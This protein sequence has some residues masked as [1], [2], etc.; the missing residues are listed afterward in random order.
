V[1][2][3]SLSSRYPKTTWLRGTAVPSPSPRE[4]AL[5]GLRGGPKRRCQ[6][7]P[8]FNKMVEF[9]PTEGRLGPW[10]RGGRARKIRM[11]RRALGFRR[12]QV[13]F[14]IKPFCSGSSRKKGR[15]ALKIKNEK[16]TRTDFKSCRTNKVPQEG[17]LVRGNWNPL[18]AKERKESTRE[19]SY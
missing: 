3:G 14:I 17:G 5:N 4:Q 10:K 8:T 19:H 2:R 18:R 7:D 15:K 1:E 12:G 6:P 9:L 11:E 16:R 13:T